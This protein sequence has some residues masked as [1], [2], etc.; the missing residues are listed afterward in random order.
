MS[1]RKPYKEAMFERSLEEWVEFIKEKV[2]N[3]A[4][5]LK[6]SKNSKD[7]FCMRNHK[8]SLRLEYDKKIAKCQTKR[9]EHFFSQ[10]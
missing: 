2:A 5:L 3:K 7:C 10:Q 8:C 9:H 1:K 6:N 4:G